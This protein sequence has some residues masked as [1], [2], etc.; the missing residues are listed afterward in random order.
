MLTSDKTQ[1]AKVLQ[2]AKAGL[3]CGLDGVVCSVKEAHFLRKNIRKKFIIITP[4]IRPKTAAKDDQKR[5]ASAQDAIKA[6]GDFLVIGRPILE[7][8]DPVVALENILKD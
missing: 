7:A 5:T 1:P 4:G 3:D 8:N 2:L 6:G